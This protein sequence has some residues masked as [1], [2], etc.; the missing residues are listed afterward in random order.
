[1]INSEE[2]SKYRRKIS[3]CITVRSYCQTYLILFISGVCRSAHRSFIHLCFFKNEPI[4]LR[5]TEFYFHRTVCK[6][7]HLEEF[8]G[9]SIFRPVVKIG[10]KPRRTLLIL[11]TN[12]A[13][14]SYK[15]QL[16]KAIYK[17]GKITTFFRLI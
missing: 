2:R 11:L 17:F 5:S 1:M 6:K 16:G 4:I 3:H 8:D 14:F 13:N 7:K 15:V 10:S 9:K 12:G